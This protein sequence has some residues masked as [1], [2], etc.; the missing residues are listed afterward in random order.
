MYVC[1]HSYKGHV[2]V[3]LYIH[4]KARTDQATC[5]KLRQ[6]RVRFPRQK[7][8]ISTPKET[9]LYAKRDLFPYHKSHISMPKNPI[10]IPKVA[11]FHAKRDLFYCQK[12]PVLLPKEAYLLAKRGLLTPAYLRSSSAFSRRLCGAKPSFHPMAPDSFFEK[13]KKKKM[14]NGKKMKNE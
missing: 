7:R 2:C 1:M 9:Y 11:Y 4:I 8:P 14:E 12:R 6:G 3:S 13:K 5:T 10:S